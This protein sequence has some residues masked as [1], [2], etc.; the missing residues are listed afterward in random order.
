MDESFGANLH[1]TTNASSCSGA[2]MSSQ[3]DKNLSDE[4]SSSVEAE[5]S[6][7]ASATPSTA[8][9]E[10][11]TADASDGKT[12]HIFKCPGFGHGG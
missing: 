1:S 6:T 7:S 12:S 8:A 10:K 11:R 4:V 9:T 2:I 3:Q 5:A